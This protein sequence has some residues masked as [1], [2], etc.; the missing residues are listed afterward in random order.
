VNIKQI[1]KIYSYCIESKYIQIRETFDL[2][3]A[4]KNFDLLLQM[5]K[6]FK[7]KNFK[8]IL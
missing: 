8:K 3:L 7:N 6:K 4:H 5:G 1:L 2:S